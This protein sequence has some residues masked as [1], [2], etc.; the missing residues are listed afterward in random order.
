MAYRP[1]GNVP[2]LL[3]KPSRTSSKRTY[4]EHHGIIA[5]ILLNMR[6]VSQAVSKDNHIY[7]EYEL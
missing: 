5:T 2:L 7:I 4:T 3:G 1:L 6:Q